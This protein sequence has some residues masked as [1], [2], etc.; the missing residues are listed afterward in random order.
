MRTFT[1]LPPLLKVLGE[2]RRRRKVQK[3]P[4]DKLDAYLQAILVA[5]SPTPS[6]ASQRK[7]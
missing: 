1:D 6:Q 4:D 5:M 7:S 3:V 2:L